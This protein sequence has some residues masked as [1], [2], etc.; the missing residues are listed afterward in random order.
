MINLP[1]TNLMF[2]YVRQE[3]LL[4]SITYLV[5]SKNNQIRA[6]FFSEK[7]KEDMTL[8]VSTSSLL[9]FCQKKFTISFLNSFLDSW[10]L[11]ENDL[12]WN[13]W[14]VILINMISSGPVYLVLGVGGASINIPLLF[15]IFLKNDLRKKYPTVAG[16]D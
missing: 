6:I 12:G 5:D 13:Y 2:N 8:R 15:F 11:R 9:D 1:T 14:F 7:F 4:F 10:C 3:N 16:N